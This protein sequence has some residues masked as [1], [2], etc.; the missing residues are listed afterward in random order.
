MKFYL[1]GGAVRDKLLNLPVIDQDWVVIG[2]TPEA[3]IAKGFKQVGADF[4]VFLHPQSK[5]EYA[6]ARQERKSGAGYK[7]FDCIF[8]PDVTLEEDLSRRDLTI[9]AMAQ[10]EAGN[11]IDPY[12]GQQDLANKR[13][14]HVSA[15]FVEDPLRVLR[16]ARFAARFHHL[17]FTIAPKT[18]SLMAKIVRAGELNNLVAERIW[19]E[20]ARALGERSPEIYFSA[21][22]ECGALKIIFPELAK[23][24]GVPQPAAYHPEIDTW[25]HS[26]MVL[27]VATQLSDDIDVRFAALIHD[28]GKG[29]TPKKDWPRHIAHETKGLIPIEN[30]CDRIKTPRDT[31]ELALLACEFHTH[32]HQVARLKNQT[33]LKFFNRADG[34]RKPERFLKLLLVCEADARGRTGFTETPYPQ[35]HYLTQVLQVLR[36]LDTKS[37]VAQ[38]FQGAKLGEEIQKKRLSLIA[39]TKIKFWGQ[40]NNE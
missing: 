28:L 9:N 20:T 7:G 17:G 10:D 11:I 33:L 30:L 18:L 38:G 21:L 23:L 8:S 1:V 14:R 29:L 4:P 32:V 39:E 22:H 12:N 5:E 19:Q 2:G 31:K 16:V 40:K 34:Q 6:L 36:A 3:L 13:L 15:A 35:R 24:S 37:L 25:V 27:Q 26:L